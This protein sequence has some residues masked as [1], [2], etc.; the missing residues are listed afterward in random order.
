[1]IPL[2]SRFRMID[3]GPNRLQRLSEDD[4]CIHVKTMVTIY[5]ANSPKYYF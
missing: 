4:S 5:F 3:L 2:G 1:M